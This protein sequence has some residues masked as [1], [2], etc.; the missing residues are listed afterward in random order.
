MKHE[1]LQ[2]LRAHAYERLDTAQ[3]RIILAKKELRESEKD[4][5]IAKSA[6]EETDLIL[7]EMDKSVKFPFVQTKPAVV[8]FSHNVI[9]NTHKE[10]KSCKKWNDFLYG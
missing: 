7:A 5:E 8:H 6:F 3:A 1:Y 4:L 2:T 10:L 9:K